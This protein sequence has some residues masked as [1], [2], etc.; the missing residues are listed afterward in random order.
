MLVL[1]A[2]FNKVL[3]KD[4]VRKVL[5]L[6]GNIK[7]WKGILGAGGEG[8]DRGWD[9]WMA[10]LTHWTWV[11]VNSG[12]W[13]WTRRPGVLQFMGSQRVRHYWATELNWTDTEPIN[14]KTWMKNGTNFYFQP[15][16]K[17]RNNLSA[18]TF[19]GQQTGWVS[20]SAPNDSIVF[21]ALF[22]HG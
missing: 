8:D 17:L 1:L 5:N 6:Q 13:W 9:G 14:F 3:Q 11:W 15:V 4:E 19:H 10:S 18:S 22:R 7:N 20:S 21:N 16:I 12:S 2:T